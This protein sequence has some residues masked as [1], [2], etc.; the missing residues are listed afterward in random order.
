MTDHAW[1]PDTWVEPDRVPLDDGT[2]LA[3]RVL[4]APARPF[5]LAHGLASNALLWRAVAYELHQ[6]GHAV[7]VVDLRG[8]GRSDRPDHGHTTASAAHDLTTVRD[9]LGWQD[10]GPVLAGQSWG[11]N[12]VLRAT[13]DDDRWGGVVAVDGGW[14]H[15]R[16][17]FADFDECWKRLAPPDFGDPP[18]DAVLER[19]GAMVADWPGDALGAIAGNLEVVDGRVRNRL[20]RDHHREILHSMWE[21]DPADL[22]PRIGIPVHLIVAGAGA[23]EDVERAMDA[24]AHATVSWHPD[25]HHDIHLQQPSVVSD[26]LLAMVGRVEGSAG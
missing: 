26:Q 23:S 24:L 20:A 11:G 22:Y 16:P 19:I 25:A 2:V 10:R 21:D 17:R 15:L 7:A 6:R 12:V 1:P 18:P 3:V 4:P 5:L 9:A 8:H 13:H 14:I